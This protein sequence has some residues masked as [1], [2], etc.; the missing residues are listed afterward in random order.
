MVTPGG[1]KKKPRLDLSQGRSA[2]CCL[3]S[4]FKNTFLD[5]LYRTAPLQTSI[6]RSHY[7]PRDP[8]AV[9]SS[10]IIIQNASAPVSISWAT[11]T[12]I[13]FG[14]TLDRGR[15]S[16]RPRRLDDLHVNTN[17]CKFLTC[18]TCICFNFFDLKKFGFNVNKYINIWLQRKCPKLVKDM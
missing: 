9:L 13:T 5:F 14:R 18:Q 10:L 3:I 17:L 11:R 7:S 15:T 12:L 16:S 6:K 8:V 2:G 4:L 1:N